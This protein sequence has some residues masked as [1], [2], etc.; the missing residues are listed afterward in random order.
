MSLSES[1]QQPGDR[2]VS[3]VLRRLE[4]YFPGDPSA[5]GIAAA[6]R[7][8]AAG[9]SELQRLFRALVDEGG[10]PAPKPYVRPYDAELDE[11]LS[12]RGW[13]SRRDEGWDS[14]TFDMWTWPPSQRFAQPTVVH[15][16]G[17]QLRV[18]YAISPILA[19][20]SLL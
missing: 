10:K 9:P 6:V 16:E 12:L 1:Q 13:R 17:L 3:S 2:A 11:A 8:G 4:Y 19:E 7:S 14:H 18:I 5:T 20:Y 15:H